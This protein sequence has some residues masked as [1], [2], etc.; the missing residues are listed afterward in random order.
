MLVYWPIHDAWS[1]PEG[2]YLLQHYSARVP[3]EL[4]GVASALWEAGYT[5]DYISDKQLADVRY[6]D[7]AL[8]IGD[9]TYK[10]VVIPKC[11]FIPVE[12]FK[13][14]IDLAKA[15]TTIIVEE[16]LPRDVPGLCDLAERRQA[17]RTL[18]SQLKPS[19]GGVYEVGHGRFLVGDKVAAL[20]S[21]AEVKREAMVERRL[22]FVRRQ[23]DDGICYFVLN[24]DEQPFSGWVPLTVEAASVAIFDPMHGGSGLLALR[25]RQMATPEVYLQL[26]PGQSCIL[27]TFD[28]EIE[29]P[30]YAYFRATRPAI[31]E[32]PWTVHFV[33]GGP[34]LPAAVQTDTLGSWTDLETEGVE[35]FSGTACYTTR[36]AKPEGDADA[37]RLDLGRVCESA[38]VVLNGVELGTL[39]GAPYQLTIP[40]DQLKA[41]NTLEVYVSNLMANRIVDL[42]RRGVNYRKFYNVNF[43]ARIRENRGRDGYF[44]AARWKPQDSGLL[45]PVTLAPL[46]KLRF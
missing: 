36:F 1:S 28:R 41:E 31:V 32:G 40:S 37:W 7:G 39:I 5:F 11:R 10:T 20:A 26:A 29:A 38:R 9:A 33:Q 45:G 34:A 21:T 22:Q 18:I 14:L 44:N 15:G 30:A 16:Q 24:S 8:H 19:D 13:V 3:S 27:R 17:L 23:L 2:R 43:P 46:L 35:T 4:S 42:D 6:A 25:R 12:T